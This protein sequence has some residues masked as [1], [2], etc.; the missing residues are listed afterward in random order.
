[1]PTSPTLAFTTPI[2]AKV[3]SRSKTTSSGV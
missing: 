2:H 3:P 1:M